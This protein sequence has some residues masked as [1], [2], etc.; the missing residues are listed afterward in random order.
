MEWNEEMNEIDVHTV[1]VPHAA[2]ED[3]LPARQRD[4]SQRVGPLLKMKY[5]VKNKLFKWFLIRGKTGDENLAKIG[6]LF[7]AKDKNA[8]HMRPFER[9]LPYI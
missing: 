3:R 7:R 4:L 2:I 5:T 9:K 6:E 1:H 8:I